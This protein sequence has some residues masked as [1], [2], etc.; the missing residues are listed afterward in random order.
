MAAAGGGRSGFGWAI[1]VA[2]LAVPGFLFYNWWSRLKAEQDRGMAAKARSRV[3]EGG[4]FQA[5]PNDGRLVN[6][7]APSSGAAA[8]V[9]Q[10]AAAQAPAPLPLPVPAASAAPAQAQPAAVPA[11]PAPAEAASAAAAAPTI[12]LRRDPM[13]SPM[14]IIRIREEELA[15][16]MARRQIEEARNRKP[17]R[18]KKRQEPPVENFLELQGIVA[19]PEGSSLAIV[20]NATVAVGQALEIEGYSE[21][22]KIVRISAL[23]VT[24]AYKGR[25]F[26]K[27]VSRDE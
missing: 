10:P 20:N 14:D 1:L 22:V 6:P 17:V 13:L 12:V 16:E 21:P 2:A 5:S 11:A 27:N 19:T 8:G 7:I 23:G 3:P 25:R 4:V 15:R 9:P 24:F 26:T 18:Q